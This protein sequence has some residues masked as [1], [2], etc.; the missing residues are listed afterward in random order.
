MSQQLC[1]YISTLP[2]INCP[3][4]CNI[5]ANIPPSIN[6]EIMNLPNAQRPPIN[7][8]SLCNVCSTNICNICCKNHYKNTHNI[9]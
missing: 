9:G 7:C 8:I 3:S 1:Q 6:I 5:G 4:C 2:Q